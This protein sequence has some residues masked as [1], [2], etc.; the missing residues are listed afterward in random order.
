MPRLPEH[1][2]NIRPIPHIRSANSIIRGKIHQ[3]ILFL[4]KLSN[5]YNK[6]NPNIKNN[7]VRELRE[8]LATKTKTSLSE[9]LFFV[10]GF[11]G[12]VR[13]VDDN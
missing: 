3:L 10:S 8:D 4:L 12:S 2:R 7:L 9:I 5:K 13:K 11:N 1:F 6:D